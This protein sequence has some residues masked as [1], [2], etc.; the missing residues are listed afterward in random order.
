M[1]KHWLAIGIFE[2]WFT[3]VRIPA[4]IWGLKPK[5]KKQYE[6][7]NVN[8][9]IWIYVTDPVVGVVGLGKPTGSFVDYKTLVWPEEKEKKKVIWPLRFSLDVLHIIPTDNWHTDRIDIRDFDLNW[10]TGFQNLQKQHI[11]ELVKRTN[12]V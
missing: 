1:E 3:S 8:D 10:Q 5:Y 2:N 12:W 6:T 4:P 11:D 7:I 9:L